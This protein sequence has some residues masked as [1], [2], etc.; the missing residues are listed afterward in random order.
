MPYLDR[1]VNYQLARAR[2]LNHRHIVLSI[3]VILLGSLAHAETVSWWRFEAGEDTDPDANGFSNPNEVAGESALVSEGAVIGTQTPDL[4]DTIVPG[5]EVSN[6]GSVRSSVNGSGGDGIFGTADYSSSL[7]VDSITVEF[8]V[9]TTESDAG[10]VARTTDANA[11]GEQGSITDGFRI[12]DPNS[13]KVDFWTSEYFEFFNTDVYF[14]TQTETTI[15]SGISINDGDWHYIAFSYDSATGR[16]RLIVDFNVTEID[17]SDNRA[18][19]WGG[20]FA[21]DVEPD[22]TVG[23]RLD[24]NPNN[25]TGTLDEIRFTDQF[26]EEQDLLSPIPEPGTFIAGLLLCGFALI[27]P[28]RVYIGRLQS[29]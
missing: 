24:G 7:N 13:V 1:A 12:V 3:I 17:L 14:G 26:E 20:S 6:T 9:R 22:V 2:M 28:L 25:Q 29:I 23:Y 15:D 18:M 19:Y 4:F 27:R 21:G 5:P 16:A 10:F 8:W 11:A